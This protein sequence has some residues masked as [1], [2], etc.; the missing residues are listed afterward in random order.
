MTAPNSPDPARLV[1]AHELARDFYRTQLLASDGPRRYLTNRG[2]GALAR[3]LRPSPA[4]VDGPWH[5]GYAPPGPTRLVEHLTR[6]GFTPDELL[7]AGLATPS[8]GGGIIDT[9]RDRIMFPVHNTDGQP[10]AFLGR[11]APG[12]PPRVPRY[13]NTRDTPIYHKGQTL[14][15]LAEQAD[16]IRL[17]WAPVM[18]EG[19]ADVLAVWLAHPD[20]LGAGR[21]AVAACGTGLTEHH[22]AAIAAA[23]GAI[24]HGITVAFDND[25]A[26]RAATMR[27]WHILPVGAGIDL[28]AARLPDAADPADLIATNQT[29]TL[30]SALGHQTVPLVEAVLDIRLHQL[31]DQHGD[32]LEHPGGQVM[33]TRALVQLLIDLSPDRIIA[34]ATR[35]AARTGVGLDTVATTVIDAIEHAPPRHGPTAPAHPPPTTPAPA[36]GSWTTPPRPAGRGRAFPAPGTPDRQSTRPGTGPHPLP[37]V[38]ARSQHR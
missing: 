29:A 14:Y 12:A 22:I 3:D 2:L 9:F 25:P 4:S 30:R 7:T 24:R 38:G 35:I 20:I 17:G 15:G 13:L 8:H 16:R 11:A 26:G 21:V 31:L 6:A 34:L 18:V 32:L 5:L 36:K 33:A 27:A 1:A 19:P 23:P 10:I 28:H 37:S